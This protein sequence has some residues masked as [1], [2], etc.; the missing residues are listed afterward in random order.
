MAGDDTMRHQ[1]VLQFAGDSDEDLANVIGIEDALIEQ[2]DAK[3]AAVDG[4]EVGDGVINLMLLAKDAM[5]LWEELESFVEKRSADGPELAAVAYRELGSDEYTV[6]WPED[7][8]GE[9]VAD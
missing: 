9:F 4:H 7:Y 8:D 3:R 6:L 2:L 5:A 1:L